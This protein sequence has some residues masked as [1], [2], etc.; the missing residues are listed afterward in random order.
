MLSQGHPAQSTP[1]VSSE[2]QAGELQNNQR[3]ERE[4]HTM[5]KVWVSGRGKL[6]NSQGLEHSTF[7]NFQTPPETGEG[8]GIDQETNEDFG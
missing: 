7:T 1:N 3:W 8:D 6:K 5:R 2:A 4:F